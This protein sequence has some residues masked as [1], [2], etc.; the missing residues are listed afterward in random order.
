[1]RP[2]VSSLLKASMHVNKHFN[3][4]LTSGLCGLEPVFRVRFLSHKGPFCS[5]FFPQLIFKN[6][7]HA[8]GWRTSFFSWTWGV[9][10]EATV[11]IGWNEGG[12]RILPGSQ[13]SQNEIHCASCTVNFTWLSLGNMSSAPPKN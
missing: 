4:C 6:L 7:S 2:S 12:P 11:L 13:L 9:C 10:L 1:M 5:L 3:N 8:A